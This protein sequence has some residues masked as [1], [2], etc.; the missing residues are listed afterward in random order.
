MFR[1]GLGYDVHRLID[2]QKS[3]RKMIL[4]GV[5]I[6]SD[7]ALEGHSDA[8]V[9]AHAIMDAVLGALGLGDIGKLF[10]DTDP[11][12]EGADSMELMRV[13]ASKMK[14]A[15]YE[16]GNVDAVVICERPKVRAHVEHMRENIAA[17]LLTEPERISVK[18]TTE[19]HLGF[20][21]RGEGIAA[22]AICL[23]Q[24]NG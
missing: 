13:V 3:G 15:G 6:P 16:I 23:L 24:K 7:L 4:G 21:G 22:E 10:P 19:E 17:A 8:D 20:T 18:G 1:V 2:A 9:L 12:Y 11:A 5:V 14:E